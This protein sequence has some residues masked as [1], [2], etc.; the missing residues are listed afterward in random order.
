MWLTGQINTS[1]K[2]LAR[3]PTSQVFDFY[4]DFDMGL[5]RRDTNN[6]N[7]RIDYSNVKGYWDSVV[8]SP[9]IQSRD[10]TR[11]F[12]APSSVDWENKYSSDGYSS[13]EDSKSF[14]ISEDIQAPL[15]W[16]TAQDCPVDGSTFDEGIGAYIEGKL[17]A[18]FLYGFSM[19]V[20]GFYLFAANRRTINLFILVGIP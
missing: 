19:V 2:H 12:F 3:Q 6:T 4:F 5:V 20:S 15:L 18:H 7:I 13:L 11:R 1:P 10:L 14:D 8:N 9:G 16:Q 17:N